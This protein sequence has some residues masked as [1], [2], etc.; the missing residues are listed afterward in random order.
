MH[1]VFMSLSILFLVLLLVALGVSGAY[2]LEISQSNVLVDETTQ[3]P[4][5][6]ISLFIPQTQSLLFSEI[7]SGAQDAAKERNLA[8][9]IHPIAQGQ[10]HFQ[11]AQHTGIHGAIVYPDLPLEETKSI[12]DLL[13]RRG[14]PSVLV[15]HAVLDE[16][17]WPY[18]G[19]NNFDLGRVVGQTLVR[20]TQEQMTVAVVYSDK[21]PGIYAEKELVEMGISTAMGRQLRG[22]IV[23]LRTDINPLRAEELMLHILRN[24]PDIQGIVFT[25][26][27][28]TLAAAQVLIDLN[29]VGAVEMI[30]FGF[31]DPIPDYLDKGILTGSLGVNARNIGYQAVAM[32]QNLINDGFTSAFVDTGVEMFLGRVD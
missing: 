11:M 28:D 24:R 8:L 1:K 31:E 16:S 29:M 23:R 9:S 13:L 6:H 3:P 7:I 5:H 2:I 25:D 26:V 12:L 27:N 10:P 17:P 15:E 30:G 20:T 4:T 18:V 21:S 14:I 22:P 32:I 19:T